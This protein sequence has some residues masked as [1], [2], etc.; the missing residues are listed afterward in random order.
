PCRHEPARSLNLSTLGATERELLFFS[1]ALLILAF[2]A[3]FHP[4]LIPGDVSFLT[5]KGHHVSQLLVVPRETNSGRANLLPKGM[6]MRRD[7][8]LPRRIAFTLIELLVVI[9]VI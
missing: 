1:A 9:A 6:A 4:S 5:T 7:P 3:R 8:L 2:L